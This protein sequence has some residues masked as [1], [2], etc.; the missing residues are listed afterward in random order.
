M[1]GIGSASND[2]VVIGYNSFGSTGALTSPYDKGRTAT[3]ELAHWLGLRH[4]SGDSFCGDDFCGDTPKQE[5]L[6]FGCVSP[7][8][9]YHVNQCSGASPNGEMTMNFMDYTD[10]ACMFMFTNDQATRMQTAMQNGTFRSNLT[11]QSV[12]LCNTSI[13]PVVAG[14][15]L[16][17]NLCTNTATTFK[18]AS[19][20]TGPFTYSWS[21][22]PSAGVIINSASSANPLITFSSQGSYTVSLSVSNSISS[23]A[24]TQ[25]VGAF[26][27]VAGLACDTFSNF[28]AVTH[29]ATLFSAG[30]WGYASGHNFQGDISKAEYFSPSLYPVG[31]KLTGAILYFA[32]ADAGSSAS[33]ISIA[34]WEEGG[35][36]PASTIGTPQQIP[37]NSITAGNATSVSFASPIEVGTNGFYLGIDGLAYG[38]PQ[39]TVALV[40]NADGDSPAATAWEQWSNNQWQIFD[41]AGSWNL[42]ISNAVYA[43]M[44]D[45]SVGTPLILNASAE[46]LLYPNP[47]TN[48][49]YISANFKKENNVGFNITNSIGQLVSSKSF[50]HTSG[51]TFS[52]NTSDLSAGIYFLTLT[53]EEKTVTKRFVIEK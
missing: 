12:T 53:S 34:V 6:H 20:G 23:D 3:H 42:K 26:D 36:G 45:A 52:I 18:G 1:I 43:V 10:D 9:P 33:N 27:C 41:G 37:I 25:S 50:M 47:A 11:N 16:P 13:Q 28:D 14:F 2:G 17:A 35:S 38:T 5:T 40:T 19:T 31:W 15:S 51:G 8:T 22:S 7:L 46:V 4:T 30:G 21:V 48:S 39:D 29:T 32:K 49:L 44:C 24:I